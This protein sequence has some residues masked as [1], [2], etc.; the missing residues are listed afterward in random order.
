MPTTK[1]E[2]EAF[3][4]EYLSENLT[5]EVYTDFCCDDKRINVSVS[6]DGK[7]IASASDYL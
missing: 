1:E 6:L 4:R 2:L 3:V 7:E 5:I